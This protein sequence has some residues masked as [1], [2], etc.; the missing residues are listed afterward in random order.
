MTT[1]GTVFDPKGLKR[2]PLGMMGP[3]LGE[4]T[5][6]TVNTILFAEGA[7]PVPWTKPEDLEVAP[8]RPLPALGGLWEG[9][10]NVL[11]LDG[12][13]EFVSDRVSEAT[14]RAALSPRGNDRLGPDWPKGPKK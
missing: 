2:G 7:K 9:G 3:S 12:H 4:I 11:L 6:G 10:Y 5:D 1:P 14:L 8:D 13:V